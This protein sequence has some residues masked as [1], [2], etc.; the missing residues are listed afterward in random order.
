MKICGVQL[1]VDFISSLCIVLCS[2]LL[3]VGPEIGVLGCQVLDVH[4]VNDLRSVDV[5]GRWSVRVRK[6]D[7]CCLKQLRACE[8]C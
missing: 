6:M 2:Y 3:S 5:K 1:L 8:S 4:W 7:C